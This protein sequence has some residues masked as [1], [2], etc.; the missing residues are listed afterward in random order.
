MRAASFKHVVGGGDRALCG[1]ALS[2]SPLLDEAALVA[3][4]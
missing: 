4:R 3:A 1:R 2:G